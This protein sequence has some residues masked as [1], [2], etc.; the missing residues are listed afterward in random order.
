MNPTLNLTLKQVSHPGR[1]SVKIQSLMTSIMLPSNYKLSMRFYVNSLILVE[2][3]GEGLSI[4]SFPCLLYDPYP[5]KLTT[6][7]LPLA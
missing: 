5:S 7:H 1:S 4:S 6:D 3:P 2:I